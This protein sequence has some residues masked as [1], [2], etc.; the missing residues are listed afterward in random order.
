[1]PEALHPFGLVPAG[2][3]PPRVTV[4][5][6]SFGSVK[7]DVAVCFLF[8][9]EKTP[10]ANGLSAASALAKALG[11]VLRGEP[12]KGKRKELAVWPSAGRFPASRYVIAGLGRRGDLTPDRL[13]EACGLA[14]RRA[15]LL[16]AKRLVVS[17][18]PPG[19]HASAADLAHAATE[20]LALGSYRLTKYQTQDDA[21][22]EMLKSAEL[23]VPRD[24]MKPTL[25]GAA[26]GAISATATNLVRD[27][28]NEPAMVVTPA[29]MAEIAQKIAKESGCDI[30]VYER[31]DL[32]RL[33]MRA[34]LGVSAGSTQPPCLI[35]MIYKP[36][37]RSGRKA[38]RRIALVG[39]GLT[40]DSGG[41]SLKTAT[42]ME[43]MKLDKAGATVVLAVMS[44]LKKLDLPLEVHGIMGMTENMPGGSALKPGDV[45]HTMSGR[46]IE[47]LNT[48]AEGRLV[49]AD[50]LE[51][52]Q[53]QKPDQIIDLATLTGACM[54]ALGPS[55]SGILGT[56]QTLVDD[57]MAAAERAG[58]KMWQLPLYEDYRD[59]I[60][61]DVADVKNS[62]STR[63]GGAITAAL[64]LKNFVTNGVPWVH[65]DIA[66][67]AFFESEQ[68]YMRKGA[69]GAPV[70]TL[71]QYLESLAGPRTV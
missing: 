62:P 2:T 69:T 33:G 6:S 59:L 51:F 67:P 52:A 23:L 45:L 60:R 4:S 41:L 40:F 53:Q 56:D 58:E 35:H 54:V 61:S 12:M 7:A 14:A 46:T 1:M 11:V 32:E 64:F 37:A 16:R 3:Q 36:R 21:R 34:I 27:L 26:R 17:M 65:L 43:T 50:A 49:L 71:I 28:V 8:E 29:R 70:R 38:L 57:L 22:A 25:S 15:A 19:P 63:Y 44:V 47:V 30:R 68:G 24:A 10:A 42:G 31:K 39:K 18:P 5:S 9:G 48:D 55:C 20:G 66:G 13:R